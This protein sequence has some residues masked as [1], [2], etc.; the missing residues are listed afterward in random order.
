MLVLEHLALIRKK[1]FMV[2]EQA[3][4]WSHYFI[5][6]IILTPTTVTFTLLN[7]DI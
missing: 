1:T 6:I 4:N 5:F 7:A 3:N 2:R